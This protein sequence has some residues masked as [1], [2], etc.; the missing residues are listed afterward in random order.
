MNIVRELGLGDS[1]LQP[2]FPEDRTISNVRGGGLVGIRGYEGQIAVAVF[3]KY[4]VMLPPPPNS[5]SPMATSVEY[6]TNDALSWSNADNMKDLLRRHTF[7]GAGWRVRFNDGQHQLQNSSQTTLIDGCAGNK[8]GFGIPSMSLIECKLA[9]SFG[10]ASASWMGIHGRGEPANGELHGEVPSEIKNSAGFVQEIADVATVDMNARMETVISALDL[11]STTSADH[12]MLMRA[13]EA[14]DST[15]W[16]AVPIIS[17][18]GDMGYHVGKE[19]ANQTAV[20]EQSLFKMKQARNAYWRAED[21]DADITDLLLGT[22]GCIW[23]ECNGKP[24]G[25]G[26]KGEMRCLVPWGKQ[27]LGGDDAGGVVDEGTGEDTAEAAAGDEKTALCDRKVIKIWASKY[28]AQEQTRV[29]FLLHE[30]SGEA[31]LKTWSTIKDN[32]IA[33]KAAVLP[34]S[35][36]SASGVAPSSSLGAPSLRNRTLFTKLSVN[37]GATSSPFSVRSRGLA[38][39]ITP[40]SSP[41]L[42]PSGPSS[43]VVSSGHLLASSPRLAGRRFSSMSLPASPRIPIQQHPLPTIRERRLLQPWSSADDRVQ[44]QDLLLSTENGLLMETAEEKL[45]QDHSST[46]GNIMLGG[47]SASQPTSPRL[48]GGLHSQRTF[49]TLACGNSHNNAAAATQ[50][51]HS[52]LSINISPTD[53][54]HPRSAWSS[55]SQLMM[56]S[57]GMWVTIPTPHE[58]PLS[59]A[60]PKVNSSSLHS[61][62]S[63]GGLIRLTSS[64]SLSML[65]SSSSS[66]TASISTATAAF[67]LNKLKLLSLDRQNSKEGAEVRPLSDFPSQQ[68]VSLSGGVGSTALSAS[69]GSTILENDIMLLISGDPNAKKIK[70]QQQQQQLHLRGSRKAQKSRS[71][72]AAAAKQMAAAAEP[73]LSAKLAPLMTANSTSTPLLAADAAMGSSSSIYDGGSSSAAGFRAAVPGAPLSP[74]SVISQSQRKTCTGHNLADLQHDEEPAGSTSSSAGNNAAAAGGSTFDVNELQLAKRGTI[75]PPLCK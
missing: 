36:T 28:P 40:I 45:S 34:T 6:G 8:T 17:P 9:A 14:Q 19:D 30:Y 10:D 58:Q 7:K 18:T 63:T 74:L 70:Q 21:V 57:D 46:L 51:R 41:S 27:I 2:P 26:E 50:R 24:R 54:G 13:D 4:T 67:K 15:T 37:T 42:S 66:S 16:H 35:V 72:G 75:L 64:K 44:F 68:N 62:G 56:G 32:Q 29:A 31:V 12:M 65:S 60:G 53:D 71:W 20:Y 69:S 1:C 3:S 52:L 25:G 48:F 11:S 73:S 55:Q 23:W 43:P 5:S 49:G 61:A 39:P 59:P 47:S 38:A 22:D 33:K